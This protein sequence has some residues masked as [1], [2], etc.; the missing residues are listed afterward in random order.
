M[1]ESVKPPNPPSDTGPLP[2]DEEAIRAAVAALAARLSPSG[3]PR[4]SPTKEGTVTLAPAAIPA[5]PTEAKP[6]SPPPPADAKP[7]T[8]PPAQ[9]SEPAP[10][11]APPAPA[12]EPQRVDVP[13]APELPPVDIAPPKP[14]PAAAPPTFDN[15]FV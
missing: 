12:A 14:N 1:T 5:P 7:S 3:P 13:L 6:D 8:P 9:A 4:Q 2:T 10:A 15:V 11:A